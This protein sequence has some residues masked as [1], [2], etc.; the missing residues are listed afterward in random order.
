[1]GAGFLATMLDQ[2][3]LEVAHS[4]TIFPRS[5]ADMAMPTK[6]GV[7]VSRELGDRYLLRYLLREQVGRFTSGSTDPHW[8]TPTPYSREEL[9]GYLALP[10]PRK[11]R[12]YVLVLDPKKI[13]EIKGPR[14]VRA[15]QGI[16]YLLPM[17]FPADAVAFKTG[18]TWEI[19][20][21]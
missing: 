21:R 11:R 9:T 14:W 7:D 19:E 10:N 13:A 20:I 1:M 4:V 17:G 15:G 5:T 18:P 16:E 12:T 3:M 6:T 2:E 8:V